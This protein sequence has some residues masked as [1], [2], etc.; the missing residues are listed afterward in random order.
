[1]VIDNWLFEIS[2]FSDCFSMH[3]YEPN[4]PPKNWKNPAIIERLILIPFYPK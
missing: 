4:F 1:M 2:F 3:F